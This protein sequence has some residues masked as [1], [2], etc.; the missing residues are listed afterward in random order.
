M[1]PA[2]ETGTDR[3]GPLGRL[4]RADM[5]VGGGVILGFSSVFGQLSYWVFYPTHPRTLPQFP[6]V[7]CPSAILP[8]SRWVGRQAVV[9]ETCLSHTLDSVRRAPC[10][11]GSERGDSDLTDG[12]AVRQWEAQ[13]W[14][15]HVSFSEHFLP[16]L[17]SLYFSHDRHTQAHRAGRHYS[18][19]S[20]P[21]PKCFF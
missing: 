13:V 21:S 12:Q 6:L 4:N 14:T 10:L 11:H 5:E 2:R 17:L 8:F 16:S 3:M 19:A 20:D 18:P 9:G 1:P 15:V 7:P